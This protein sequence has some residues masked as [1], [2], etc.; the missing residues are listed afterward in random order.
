M[1]ATGGVATGIIVFCMTSANT[2]AGLV[3]YSVFVENNIIFF[4]SPPP[5]PLWHD[6]LWRVGD[7]VKLPKG[8]S[9]YRHL[10][11]YGNGS[12]RLG[13]LGQFADERGYPQHIRRI[14]P[15]LHVQRAGT[16]A[17]IGRLT[18]YTAQISTEEGLLGQVCET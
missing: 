18:A 5:P 10:Y 7:L 2:N 4:F 12:F 9:R 16:M 14:L 8:R 1:F 13:S 15:G 3:V 17:V 6:H 11:G